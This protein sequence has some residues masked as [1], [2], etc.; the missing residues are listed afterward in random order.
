[1]TQI[2]KC[3]FLFIFYIQYLVSQNSEPYVSGKSFFGRSVKNYMLW[4][5]PNLT[6]NRWAQIEIK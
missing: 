4:L 5:R 1:M 2:I 6:S 3:N